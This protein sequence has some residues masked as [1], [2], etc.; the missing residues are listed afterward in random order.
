MAEISAI[1]EYAKPATW[2]RSNVTG[3]AAVN[4]N[5]WELRALL[6]V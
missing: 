1:F 2:R 6:W 3:G 5:E 4:P